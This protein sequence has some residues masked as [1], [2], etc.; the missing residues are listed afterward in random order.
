MENFFS[1]TNTRKL[2]KLQLWSVSRCNKFWMFGSSDSTEKIWKNEFSRCFFRTNKLKIHKSNSTK[3]AAA[4]AS[5]SARSQRMRRSFLLRYLT[6]NKFHEVILFSSFPR[7]IKRKRKRKENEEI[8]LQRHKTFLIEFSKCY[9]FW[10]LFGA[11]ASTQWAQGRDKASAVGG[12]KDLNHSLIKFISETCFLC[13]CVRFL[14]CYRWIID[15]EAKENLST[16]W[17]MKANKTRNHVFQHRFFFCFWPVDV[18]VSILRSL[19]FMLDEIRLWSWALF[20]KDFKL[21]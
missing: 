7:V 12:K 4:K 8:F 9:N 13:V 15:I 11:Q 18:I 20:S 21:I 16:G 14:F 3:T 5:N 6:V 10:H 2:S 1:L 19:K 17:R